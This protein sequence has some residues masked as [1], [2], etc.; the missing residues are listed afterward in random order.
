M[1]ASSSD[2]AVV[3]TPDVTGAQGSA[4]PPGGRPSII[5]VPWDPESPDHV[6]RMRL[7]RVACGWKQEGAEGWRPLQREGKIGL[8]W[9]VSDPSSP[10]PRS[11]RHTWRP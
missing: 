9:I 10:S 4:T 5:L 2:T 6:E 7:Q 11:P 1:A 3:L 8:H